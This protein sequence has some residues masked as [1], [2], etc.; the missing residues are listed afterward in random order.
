MWFSK[1]GKN[2]IS[3]EEVNRLTGKVVIKI[4]VHE[5]YDLFDTRQW[6]MVFPIL[7]T[8]PLNYFCGENTITIL[9]TH[10]SRRTIDQLLQEL[11]VKKTRK[12]DGLLYGPNGPLVQHGCTYR[13][14]AAKWTE[15]NISRGAAAPGE[16][17]DHKSTRHH[18]HTATTNSRVRTSPRRYSALTLLGSSCKPHS[19]ESLACRC[20]PSLR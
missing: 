10:V 15:M 20:R 13:I 6:N 8:R 19:Q 17:V 7:S 1:E 3:T 5:L 16:Y 18:I 11:S 14:E 12:R 4:E 9:S 2:Q